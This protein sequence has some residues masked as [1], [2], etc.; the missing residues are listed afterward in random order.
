[1]N[2]HS[3]TR[4]GTARQLRLSSFWFGISFLWGSFLAVVLPFLLLPAHPGPGNPALVAASDKNTAL[5][6]LEGLGLV[7]AIVVQPA[8]GAWS[9]RL[10]TR[11]GRRRPLIVL[12]AAGGVVAL[13]LMVD[14]ASF[15]WVLGA[16]CLLQFCMNVGQGA[17]QGLMPDSVDTV[18]RGA[19]S[20]W[21]GVATLSGQVAGVLAGGLLAPR[22]ALAPIAAVVAVTALITVLGVPERGLPPASAAQSQRTRRQIVKDVRGYAAEFRR[23]PDFCWVVLSRFLAYTGLACIQRFAANYLRDTFHD[24]HLFGIN[25]GGAQAATGIVFA[26]VILCGLL[27]TYPAVRLSERTG[28]RPILI[29]A[30]ISGAIGSALFLAAGSLTVVVLDAMLVGLA[31]G[32]LVSVDWAYMVDLAPRRRSG[33]FLGFSNVATAG[34]QAAAPFLLGPVIDAVNRGGGNNGYKVLFAAAALFM[35]AGGAVLG[36]VRARVAPSSADT[37]ALTSAT[38]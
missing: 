28:R 20:G 9:D 16:Y 30:T 10:R 3:A 8:A 35:L 1:M 11:W 36:Q 32:M 15:W 2:A 14:A 33:K 23:Y 12:G 25:L 38:D 31:F 19:A 27:A 6:L 21:L 18:E 22:A 24:Y 4:L 34:S 7:L 5:A 17:Y 29:A 13:L 26:V 37:L